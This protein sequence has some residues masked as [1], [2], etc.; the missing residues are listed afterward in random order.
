MANKQISNL[1]QAQDSAVASYDWTDI[2][3]GE[4][5]INFYP[6]LN[7][8][9]NMLLSSQ[10]LPS[11]TTDGLYS[12]TDLRSISSNKL[13]KQ[14]FLE[15]EGYLSGY[16]KS[17]S[18][19]IKMK[20]TKETGAVSA[21]GTLKWTSDEG[22]S[23][24]S[25]ASELKKTIYIP[26]GYYVE[27]LTYLARSGTSYD[28]ITVK[29]I[30]HYSDTTSEEDEQSFNASAYLGR[31]ATNPTQTKL[32]EKIEVWIAQSGGTGANS[33]FLIN[34]TCPKTPIKIGE[35]LCLYITKA[36]TGNI[37]VDPLNLIA[38]ERSLVFTLPF[39]IDL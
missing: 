21:T 2:T 12:T 36:G 37:I 38:T 16:M 23:K 8:E 26:S 35:K 6:T 39:R 5:K 30:F 20:L 18:S 1:F 34:F 9:Q 3:E 24:G 10:A 29:I 32:V 4:G 19:T 25:G 14:M 33:S 31:T 13:T 15:G 27:K 17:S 22:V 28:T 11:T 7:D